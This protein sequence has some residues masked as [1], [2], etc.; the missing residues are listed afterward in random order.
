MNILK[1]ILVFILVLLLAVQGNGYIVAYAQGEKVCI[2][3][4]T[5]DYTT[6]INKLLDLANQS[7]VLSEDKNFSFDSAV[8]LYSDS[9]NSGADGDTLTL[10]VN[11][12]VQEITYSDGS[13]ERQYADATIT[14]MASSSDSGSLPAYWGKYDIACTFL[15]YYTD[16]YGGSVVGRRFD[17]CTFK[18]NDAGTNSIYVSK[19][20][21]A[22]HGI[23]DPLLEPSIEKYATYYNPSS[24]A[25]YTLYSGDSRIYNYGYLQMLTCVAIVTLSDGS[26]SDYGMY[27]NVL[28][29]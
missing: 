7:S 9:I 14:L 28:G 24:G 10:E 21:M 17:Y 27:I 16:F 1:K 29:S 8:S 23:Y 2:N 6:D 25:T 19:L 15:A 11:Q 20:E 12:L 13:I 22:S 4:Q 26:V 3:I 18:F 5:Y